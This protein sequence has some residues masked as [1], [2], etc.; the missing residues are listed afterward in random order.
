MLSQLDGE[1]FIFG[2]RGRI[3]RLELVLFSYGETDWKKE[4][5]TLFWDILA[6]WIV[7]DEGSKEE[8]WCFCKDGEQLLFAVE[9]EE[10]VRV[11][12]FDNSVQLEGWAMKDEAEGIRRIIVSRWLELQRTANGYIQ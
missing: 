7:R 9:D 10:N 6:E 11:Y 3:T 1:Q 12:R 2:E 4:W 8:G 5:E